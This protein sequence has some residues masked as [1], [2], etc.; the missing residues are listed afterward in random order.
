VYVVEVI[1]NFNGIAELVI[2]SISAFPDVGL[3][4]AFAVFSVLLVLP[5]MVVLDVIQA[6]VDPRIREGAAG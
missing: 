6:L 2:R 1:F 5:L 3:A 4:A